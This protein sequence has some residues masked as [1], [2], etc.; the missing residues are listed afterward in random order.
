MVTVDNLAGQDVMGSRDTCVLEEGWM[1]G[2][3]RM[4]DRETTAFIAA[5]RSCTSISEEQKSFL[6]RATFWPFF[7]TLP[8]VAMVVVIVVAVGE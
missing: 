7:V 2:S 1:A 3:L 4:T 6:A 8:G 5:L